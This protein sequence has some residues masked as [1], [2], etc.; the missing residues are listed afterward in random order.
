MMTTMIMRTRIREQER[1]DDDHHDDDHE[2]DA[3]N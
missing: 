3:S 2:K 1:D